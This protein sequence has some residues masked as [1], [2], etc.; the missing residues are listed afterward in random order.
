MVAARGQH[1][2][3]IDASPKA[4]QIAKRKAT[5]R[6]VAAH[7]VVSDALALADLNEKFDTVLD[8]G[9]FHVFDDERRRVTSP[10]SRL[11]SSPQGACCSLASAIANPAIGGPAVSGRPNCE[12]PLLM[13]GSLN[14]SNQYGSTPILSHP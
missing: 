13:A 8:S 9:L 1:A 6:G 5:D 11:S 4:I 3:G 2:T 10:H 12:M 7:F 14:R